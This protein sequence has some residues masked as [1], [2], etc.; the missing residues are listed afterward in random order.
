MNESSISVLLR[1]K[2]LSN[3]KTPTVKSIFLVYGANIIN[4][5]L[6][7]CFIVLVIRCLSPYEYGIYT[8]FSATVAFITGL[9]GSG[10]NISLVRFA[11]EA[12]ENNKQEEAKAIFFSSL[13][14]QGVL[15][16]F[17]IIIGLFYADPMSKSLFN[18]PEISKYITLAALG[19][20]GPVLIKFT[21][22][23][24]QTYECF[25]KF[26]L[27]N[28]LKNI[29]LLIGSLTLLRIGKFDLT[30]LIIIII[31]VP[32]G[33]GSYLVHP[34]VRVTSLTSRV[35]RIFIEYAKSNCWLMLYFLFL[36][37]LSRLDVFMLTRMRTIEEVAAYGVAFK[38]YSLLLLL[39]GSVHTVFLPKLSKRGSDITYLRKF[40]GKWM[41]K[42]S[43]IVIPLILLLIILAKPLMIFL[44]GEQYATSI[45]PFQIFCI[46]AII[47]LIFSPLV[48][49][50]VSMSKYRLLSSLG[51]LALLFNFSGNLYFIPLYGLIGATG[52]TIITHAIIN[53]ASFFFAWRITRVSGYKRLK[54][55]NIILR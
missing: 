23:V 31:V 36:S 3:F 53:L 27:I 50:L 4:T 46:G 13:M 8:T 14:F 33:I 2:I 41:K 20:G 35:K 12:V 38:Y 37:L 43:A 34:Y 5:L 1:K 26:S 16:L 39:L 25:G 18:R 32:A 6:G 29:A 24:Y 11:A 10:F 54:V 21:A 40:I 15:L 7:G 42:S 22:S 44:N 55:N 52:I 30:T 49:I 48:N 9:V 19:V 45:L 51:F 28:N 47:S 17:F